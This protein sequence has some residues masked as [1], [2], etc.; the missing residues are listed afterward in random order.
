MAVVVVVAFDSVVQVWSEGGGG[1]EKEEE[2]DELRPSFVSLQTQTHT[3]GPT[4]T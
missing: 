1:G 3:S 4:S 2:R